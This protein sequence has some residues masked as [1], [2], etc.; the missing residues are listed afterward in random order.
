MYKS[1]ETSFTMASPRVKIWARDIREK[2]QVLD[3]ELPYK[4]V[5]QYKQYE[6]QMEI[7]YMCSNQ[8]YKKESYSCEVW[9]VDNR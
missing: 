6:L 5:A 1:R 9:P 3:W 7:R 4:L 2:K 8:C